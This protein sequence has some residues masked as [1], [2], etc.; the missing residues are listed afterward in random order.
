MILYDVIIKSTR[1]SDKHFLNQ[2]WC[3]YANRS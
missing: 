3:L 2:M 1:N